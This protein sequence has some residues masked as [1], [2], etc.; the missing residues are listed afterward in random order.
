MTRLS[1]LAALLFPLS[2]IPAQ[3]GP[4]GMSAYDLHMQQAV[5][6]NEIAGHIASPDDARQLV[7]MIADMF[8]DDLPPQWTTRGIRRRI[9]QAEYE[10]ATDP[11]KLI[12][13][14]QIADAWN[15]FVTEIGAPGESRVSADEIHYMRDSFYTTARIFWRMPRHQTIYSMPAIYAAGPDETVADGARA[16]ETVRILWDLANEPENLQIARKQA[17]KGILFSEYVKQE[18]IKHQNDPPRKAQGF[19]TLR[20]SPPNPITVAATKYVEERG[21]KAMARAIEQLLSDALG[22]DDRN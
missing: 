12:P 9:A 21:E 15:R 22:L 14:E 13:D 18:R 17:R 2:F 1:I 16:V 5:R 10:T 3:Q 4:S 6:M 20:V 19:V 7:D 11:A 8:A